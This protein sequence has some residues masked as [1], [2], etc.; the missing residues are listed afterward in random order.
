MQSPWYVVSIFGGNE[1]PGNVLGEVGEEEKSR[2]ADLTS[3]AATLA[4]YCC[5]ATSE[6]PFYRR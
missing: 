1:V 6:S 4:C 3:G 5:Y 2:G